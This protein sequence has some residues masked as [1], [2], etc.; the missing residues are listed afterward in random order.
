LPKETETTEAFFRRFL[1]IQ[2]DVKISEEE[3]DINIANKIIRNELPGVFNWA[4]EGL[5]R[6]M[7]QQEFTKC[8]KAEIALREFRKQADS[9]Q[10]FIEENNYISSEI[11]KESLTDLYRRYKEF[12][13]EDN[14]KPLGKVRFSKR[15]EG[16]GF[17][18]IR[19]ND[20]FWFCI[21]KKV[22]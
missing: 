5:Q 20:G 6:L 15:F 22:S 16:K 8:E 2:F 7:V 4:L 21:E 13:K 14:Y 3:K 17:Q 1:I 12:C 18:K 11:F 19:M 9:V 10:L